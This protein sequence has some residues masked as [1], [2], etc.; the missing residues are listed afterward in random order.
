MYSWWILLIIILVSS[1]PVILIYIWYRLAKYS[2][3]LIQF[4]IVL[5]AGAAAF[6]PA[7]ILQDILNFSF[8]TDSRIILFYHV[9]IRV[10]FTE[11]ISRLFIL[12]IFFFVNSRIAN[13]SLNQPSWLDLKKGYAVGLVAGLGFAILENAVYAASDTSILI[14]RTV[15]AAP[16]HAA[17]G[18]RVGAAAIMVRSNP[19]QAFF[20][21]FT[22]VAIHGIYNFMSAIPG[23]SSMAAVLIAITALTSSILSIRGNWSSEED[24]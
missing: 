12:S 2:I 1:I 4:L 16:L 3:S 13:A 22:A 9:F 18:S 14:L 11:E 24:K 7:L 20:R 5:L 17:C 6:F 8:S 10:A 21:L 23:I 15:T 19:I